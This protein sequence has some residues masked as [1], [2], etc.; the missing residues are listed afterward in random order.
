MRESGIIAPRQFAGLNEHVRWRAESMA[1]YGMGVVRG[2]RGA[3]LSWCMGRL[4]PVFGSVRRQ[5]GGEEKTN[6]DAWKSQTKSKGD[7]IF[8]LDMTI[9]NQFVN[10]TSSFELMV[11]FYS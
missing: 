1:D 4:L 5:E 7:F 11:L 3:A 10:T 6:F 8:R 9:R 2:M